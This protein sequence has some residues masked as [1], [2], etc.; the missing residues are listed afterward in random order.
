MRSCDYP[1]VVR[2][3]D[4]VNRARPRRRPGARGSVV[5]VRRA[6]GIRYVPR[7][8]EHGSTRSVP[9]GARATRAE[10]QAVLDEAL[11]ITRPC[12]ADVLG[13]GPYCYWHGKLAAPLEVDIRPSADRWRP[14]EVHTAALEVP[15]PLERRQLVSARRGGA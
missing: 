3:T 10:A 6:K 15:S 4:G 5:A 13:D 14:I 12:G 7:V 9:G 11:A 2:D 1:I 8:V